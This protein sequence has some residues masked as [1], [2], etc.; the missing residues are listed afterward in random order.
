MLPTV[1]IPEIKEKEAIYSSSS[2][3]LSFAE[4]ALTTN[5]ENSFGGNGF[6]SDGNKDFDGTSKLSSGNDSFQSNAEF[7]PI[8]KV[9]S[10]I[11]LQSGRYNQTLNSSLVKKM[12]LHCFLTKSNTTS[13][14]HFLNGGKRGI[15]NIKICKH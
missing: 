2:K 6:G 4:L 13:L 11:K 10:D 15:D 7:K 1:R 9:P 5:N 14:I 3:T 8:V 12:N